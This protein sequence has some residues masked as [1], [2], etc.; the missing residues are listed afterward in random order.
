MGTVEPL[1]RRNF[2]E[3]AS[4]VI[5][6]RAIPDIRDGCKPVQRRI[7]HTLHTMDDGK[8]HKVANVI[9]ECMKY[10]PHGDAS[11][12]DAL[13]VL[14]NKEYFIEKQGNFGNVVSGD[15]AAAPRYI[16]CR[17]TPLAREVL[18]NPP[19]TE[20]TPSYDSR[21]QEPVFLPVKVP[22]PLL[23]G[24][25][26]IAVGMS[27]RILPH[28]FGELLQA[29][30]ALLQGRAVALAPDFLSGGLV[31]VSEYADGT[32]RVR[33]RARIESRDEKNV[34]ITA[35][36]FGVT[37]EGLIAS[38]EAAAQ[39]GKVK[40]SG[41]QD[42]STD[43]VEIQLELQRGVYASEVIPQLFAYTDCEVSIVSNIV[44]I[45]DRKPATLT[46]SDVL[47]ELTRQL[48]DRI[49]AELTHELD[50]LTARQHWL[51]LEQIFIEERVYQRIETAKTEAAVHTAVVTGMKP[52]AKRFVRE[53][54]DD[55]VKRLLEIRIR[56]ISAYDIERNRGD[57]DEVLA[58]IKEC[59][60]RLR[61]LTRTTIRYLED[62]HARYAATWPRRTEIATFDTV[63]KRAVA[64][65][66]L[67]VSYNPES[68]F[69]GTEARGSGFTLAVSEYDKILLITRDGVFRVVSPPDKIFLE[70][71]LIHASIFPEET[72]VRFT[73]LYRDG[74]KIPYAKR[75]HIERFTRGREYELIKGRSGRIDHLLDGDA[76]G[77]VH[78]EH[79]VV[80]RLR[81]KEAEFDL[82]GLEPCGIGA[83][84][85][86]MSARATAKVRLI[87]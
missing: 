85:T 44:V 71:P 48:R 83:R 10:H 7:F 27:T 33:V 50:Q 70:Q 26:G 56:R 57:I 55:D 65:S 80:P 51:T 47:A 78:L 53:M 21:R 39:K 23:L 54:V 34:V 49:K 79:Q 24:T 52:F 37:T 25:E 41:I 30:I 82:A 32:G 11:I 60:G 84:G 68:K 67:K 72:G 2:L 22:M 6:D 35:V 38:I 63:D 69:F 77:R 75:I 36:P 20:W 15:P 12:G 40:L 42:Y 86:R 28:N 9:G 14:A 59:T 13:V 43:G 62:L 58:G 8:F 61:N 87:T 16:E 64:T 18:F 1:M 5:M 46:V 31:D 74:R 73:V 4:Y 17:L 3:Y 66:N 76:T 19:L 81:V 45:R 29:Q